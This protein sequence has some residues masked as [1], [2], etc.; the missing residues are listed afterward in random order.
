LCEGNR[1]MLFYERIIDKVTLIKVPEKT[2]YGAT[3]F[4]IKDNTNYLLAFA[5]DE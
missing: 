3:E 5:G 1:E 4:S 2:F